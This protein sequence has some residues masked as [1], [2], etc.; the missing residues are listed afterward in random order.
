MN[1][2]RDWFNA[3]MGRNA[4]PALPQ[5][6]K[7]FAITTAYVELEARLNAK[8]TGFAALAFQ[9]VESTMF[10][11]LENEIKELLGVDSQIAGSTA[12]ISKDKYNYLWLLLRDSEFE[13]LVASMHLASSTLEEHDF[14]R[15]LLAA[16]FQFE[17][18][19][20]CFFWLYNFKR[21]MF[22][23]FVP[24]KDR[25]RDNVL[26]MRLKSLMAQELPIEPDPARWYPLWDIPTTERGK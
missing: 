3:L 2:L 5:S 11:R 24:I 14:G 25:Q 26:E 7:I 1:A 6:D 15:A 19:G 23:P 16:A 18:G 17:V 20:L 22:Y 9:N 8:P 12:E 10:G 21:G 4:R 13:R